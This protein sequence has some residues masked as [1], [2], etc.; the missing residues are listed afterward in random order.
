MEKVKKT[1]IKNEIKR[2]KELIEKNNLSIENSIQLY[3]SIYYSYGSELYKKYVPKYIQNADIKKLVLEQKY[4][5]IYTK[6][7]EKTF[8]K[9]QTN[10]FNDDILY[11]SG[12]I[13]KAFVYDFRNEFLHFFKTKVIPLFTTLAL[14]IPFSTALASEKQKN[15]NYKNYSNEINAYLNNVNCYGKQIANYHLSDLENIMK[16]MYDTWDNVRGYGIP[17]NDFIGYLGLDIQNGTGVCRNFADDMSRRLNAINPNYKAHSVTVDVNVSNSDVVAFSN[18]NIE[19]KDIFFETLQTNNFNTSSLLYKYP[20]KNI[21]PNHVVVFLTIPDKNIPLVVDPVN[22]ALGTF[23]DGKITFFNIDKN[24]N[25]YSLSHSLIGDLLISG[26]SGFEYSLE[27]FSN[28]YNSDYNFD[29]LNTLY[30]IDAQNKALDKVRYLPVLW[31][32][33]DD[34][35]KN[36]YDNY[37]KKNSFRNSLIVSE[38]YDYS[39]NSKIAKEINYKNNKNDKYNLER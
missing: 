38:N 31:S 8:V 36:I 3:N 13:F 23:S 37:H 10:A 16:I 9:Y 21:L 15:D 18:S 25:D 33:Y 24:N 5:D 34:Y 2:I 12:N 35:H 32:G 6:Y 1:L 7:G 20:L 17:E 27:Y 29:E 11:E 26:F 28:F 22:I 39:N 19:K 14:A 30:G 4:I